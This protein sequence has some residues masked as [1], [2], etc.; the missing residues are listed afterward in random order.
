[1]KHGLLQRDCL[2]KPSLLLFIAPLSAATDQ[3]DHLDIGDLT[4]SGGDRV[5]TGVDALQPE[6]VQRPALAVDAVA[7]PPPA[8][9][10]EE[11]VVLLAADQRGAA[12][13]AIGEEIAVGFRRAV[14]A[15]V[16]A[17]PQRLWALRIGTRVTR[18][19]RTR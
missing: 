19:L 14:E 12:K 13:P 3:H 6:L 8:E 1:M 5:G 7:G 9:T 17:D 2:T 18:R 16:F 10:E 4:R 11:A 15:D